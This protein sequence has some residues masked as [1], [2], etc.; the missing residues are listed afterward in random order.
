MYLWRRLFELVAWRKT[1]SELFSINLMRT[2]HPA[3]FKQDLERLFSLLAAGIIRPRIAERISFDEVAGAH[4]RLE[5][6]RLDGR[7][8]LCPDLK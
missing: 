4:R 5:A 1:V 7:L 3:W 2:R 6:G 8:V